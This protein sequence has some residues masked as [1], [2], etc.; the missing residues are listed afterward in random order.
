MLRSERQAVAEDVARDLQSTAKSHRL[1]VAIL[2]VNLTDARPPLE[3]E[4]DFA[5]AQ[6][7]ESRRDQRINDARSY[8]ETKA[9]TARSQAQ[10]ILEAAHAAAKRRAL[11]T[12]AQA[13]RFCALLAEAQH[14]RSL[15]IRRIY[16]ESLQALLGRVKGKIVLPPGDSVDLTVLGS[17]DAPAR[18][19]V[20]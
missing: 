5:A 6:S 8:A 16:I 18:I 3:V 20:K 17:Q 12:S 10:A 2:G 4:A 11:I 13:E 14:A 19:P 15:T 9:T 7:A 1:G